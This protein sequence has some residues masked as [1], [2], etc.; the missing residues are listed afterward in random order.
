MIYGSSVWECA[1]DRIRKCRVEC[2]AELKSSKYW[3]QLTHFCILLLPCKSKICSLSHVPQW[4]WKVLNTL[5]CILLVTASSCSSTVPYEN[6][7]SIEYGNAVSS[8]W[9]NWKVLNTKVNQSPLAF[10]CCPANSNDSLSITICDLFPY[11]WL[12]TS[13]F[14]RELY[15]VRLI[16]FRIFLTAPSKLRLWLVAFTHDFRSTYGL[17]NKLFFS[18]HSFFHSFF[19]LTNLLWC[20]SSVWCTIPIAQFCGGTYPCCSAC[21]TCHPKFYCIPFFL[22]K[23]TTHINFDHLGHGIF[24]YSFDFIPLF[25]FGFVRSTFLLCVSS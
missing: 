3:R 14:E 19:S 15:K 18:W 16:L 11:L 12:S 9:L 20:S 8:F 17:S 10:C 21:P 4:N 25:C 6:V 2:L 24:S 23:L 7:H 1:F 5:L 13:G 22:S